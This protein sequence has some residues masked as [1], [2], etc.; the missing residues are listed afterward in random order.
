M[1]ALNGR[2]ND[3]KKWSDYEQQHAEHA[4]RSR[5]RRHCSRKRGSRLLRLVP[6]RRCCRSSRSLP[7]LWRGL[8]TQPSRLIY[9]NALLLFLVPL[10]AGRPA[11]C[12]NIDSAAA[13]LAASF[14]SIIPPASTGLISSGKAVSPGKGVSSSTE[15]ASECRHVLCHLVASP[16]YYRSKYE[17]GTPQEELERLYTYR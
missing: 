8:A 13:V 9:C 10:L 6:W 7:R 14:A 17:P 15:G 12:V 5:R 11:A 16:S 2:W 4:R 3:S 1:N